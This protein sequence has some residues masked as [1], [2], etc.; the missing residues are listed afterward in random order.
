MLK[1]AAGGGGKGMRAVS[2]FEGLADEID[3]AMR[4]LKNSFGYAGLIVEKL[5]ER[6]RHIEVQ[7]AGDGKGNVIHLFEREC[8]LQRR[9]QKLI[10]EAP[11]ANLPARLREQIVADA[12]ATGRRLNYRGVGTVEF[13]VSGG[14]LLL[15]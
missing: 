13:I 3:A 9:H 12:G 15:S 4:E 8:S 7:I 6:G 11:S 14:T 5:I 10:E 2:T 1:A